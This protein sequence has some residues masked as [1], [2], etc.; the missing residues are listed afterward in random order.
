[1]NLMYFNVHWWLSEEL[2]SRSSVAF[3][4]DTNQRLSNFIRWKFAR[5]LFLVS[6]SNFPLAIKDD[7][8]TQDHS[9]AVPNNVSFDVLGLQSLSNFSVSLQNFERIRHNTN[10]SISKGLV[11]IEI[12]V[13]KEWKA[14]VFLVQCQKSI[15]V[16]VDLFHH[17]PCCNL[18]VGKLS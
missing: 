13:T 5:E 14:E 6:V 1:M 15:V 11:K 4:D 18:I 3:V 17:S 8:S 12:G 2:F 7:D 10:P 16:H 9:F